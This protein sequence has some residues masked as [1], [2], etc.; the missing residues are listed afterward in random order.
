[1]KKYT[2]R[3][4]A[5]MLAICLVIGNTSVVSA[6][7]NQD[8]TEVVEM[9]EMIADVPEAEVVEVAEAEIA[10]V[11]EAE[12]MEMT[13]SVEVAETESAE[14]TET[15]EAA[16]TE[17]V[18]VTD[19]ADAVE[20]ETAEVT[21]TEVVDPEMIEVIDAVYASAE[22]T[23]FT[24]E[25]F[26][27]PILWARIC[28]EAGKEGAESLTAEDLA[29]ITYIGHSGDFYRGW[30]EEL[31]GIGYLTNLESVYF[32]EEKITDVSPLAECKKLKTIDIREC[33]VT[34]LP[35]F[36]HLENLKTLY[37]I[38]T[39][40]PTSEISEDKYPEGVSTN[41]NAQ[42]P[43]F[44]ASVEG[45]LVCRETEDSDTYY[46]EIFLS[47]LRTYYGMDLMVEDI[48]TG[49]PVVLYQEDYANLS[50]ESVTYSDYNGKGYDAILELSDL[51]LTEGEHTWRVTWTYDNRPRTSTF[52]ITV[53]ADAMGKTW[54]IPRDILPEALRDFML[55]DYFTK[56]WDLNEDGE[57]SYAEVEKMDSLY[58]NDENVQ[59]TNFEIFKYMK[60]LGTLYIGYQKAFDDTWLET[61]CNYENIKK[62]P[63]L[64][65]SNMDKVT[66]LVPLQKLSDLRNLT[67]W[68]MT[69]ITDISSLAEVSTLEHLNMNA[70]RNIAGLSALK[71]LPLTYMFADSGTFPDKEIFDFICSVEEVTVQAGKKVS[72]VS[73]L[74]EMKDSSGVVATVEDESI[75]GTAAGAPF[76]IYGFRAGETVAHISYEGSTYPVKVIVTAAEFDYDPAVGEA[77][78]EE[79][80]MSFAGTEGITS[81]RVS[82]T[83]VDSDDNIW[84]ITTR[85]PEKI[86][87]KDDYTKYA[88]R[89]LY[90]RAKVFGVK[91][92]VS[93]VDFSMY[94]DEA[95][96]LWAYTQNHHGEYSNFA[97]K[98]EV[99]KN[100]ADWQDGGYS[101]ESSYSPYNDYLLLLKTDGSL[102]VYGF[103]SAYNAETYSNSLKPQLLGKLA[104][105][106]VTAIYPH[107][108]LT[109]NG[110]FYRVNY[111]N[112]SIQ[113]KL[114]AENVVKV[115]D[116]TSVTLAMDANGNYYTTKGKQ[117]FTGTVKDFLQGSYYDPNW[118]VYDQ[119]GYIIRTNSD[120]MH[121]GYLLMEDGTLYRTYNS[122]A[123]NY[124]T[125]QQLDVG[126]DK[127]EK[128]YYWKDGNAYAYSGVLYDEYL[129]NGAGRGVYP[130]DAGDGTQTLYVNGVPYLSK[131]V[132]WVVGDSCI[133]AIRVDNTLWMF[134]ENYIPTQINMSEL[135]QDPIAQD[136]YYTEIDIADLRAGISTLSIDWTPVEGAVSYNAYIKNF[137][138]SYT[139]ETVETTGYT[140]SN[141][142]QK[143][144]YNFYIEAV[145]A[146][147]TVIGSSWTFS[148]YTSSPSLTVEK[149]EVERGKTTS[150]ATITVKVAPEDYVIDGQLYLYLDCFNETEEDGYVDSVYEVKEY[151]ECTGGGTYQL[152]ITGAPND[153]YLS[154]NV[155]LYVNDSSVVRQS[156]SFDTKEHLYLTKEDF[157][158]EALWAIIQDRSY[159]LDAYGITYMYIE[160]PNVKDLTGLDKLV[161]LRSLNLCGLDKDVIDI[162]KIPVSVQELRIES[163]GLV[164]IPDLSAF[165][166]LSYLNLYMNR[167]PESE[168]VA[169][170]PALSIFKENYE[171]NFNSWLNGQAMSQLSDPVTYVSD[172]YYRTV[173]NA[174]PFFLEIAKVDTNHS[175][176][177]R[178]EENGINLGTTTTVSRT[179]DRIHMELADLGIAEAC[180]KELSIEVTDTTS[181]EI[182]YNETKVIQFRDGIN[183]EADK[184][185]LTLEGSGLYFRFYLTEEQ[186]DFLVSTGWDENEG[187][188]YGFATTG[189]LSDINGKEAEAYYTIWNEQDVPEEYRIFYRINEVHY[190]YAYRVEVEATVLD[191]QE[192]FVAGPCI[193]TMNGYDGTSA[194]TIDNVAEFTDKSIVHGVSAATALFD[195]QGEYIYA[196][197]NVSQMSSNIPELIVTDKNGNNISS[198]PYELIYAGSWIYKI[199]PDEQYKNRE[200]YYYQIVS[201]YY[202]GELEGY[203]Y[204]ERETPYA[205]GLFVDTVNEEIV[206]YVS[207]GI[208]DGTKVKVNIY[209]RSS[210]KLLKST[211]ATVKNREIHVDFK[212]D[213]SLNPNKYQ[214]EI[215]QGDVQ[216]RSR[217]VLPGGTLGSKGA[218]IATK[219]SGN[220]IYLDGA[221][222][223]LGATI[224]V[225]DPKDATLLATFENPQ[226]GKFESL[227]L[228]GAGL[229]A[230]KV[231]LVNVLFDGGC[232]A[233]KGLFDI[234]TETKD[235][236]WKLYDLNNEEVAP[237]GENAYRLDYTAALKNKAIILE[238]QTVGNADA[239]IKVTSSNTSV[240]SAALVKG[241]KNIKLTVKGVGTAYITVQAQDSKYSEK[242]K[243][244]L[245]DYLPRMDS[246]TLALNR[247]MT[248]NA[249]AAVYPVYNT[250]A[251]AVAINT[252]ALTAKEVTANYIDYFAVSLTET[253]IKVTLLD[254]SERTNAKGKLEAV[255]N[256]TYRIPII[257]TTEEPAETSATGEVIIREN[258]MVLSVKLS[259]TKPTITVKQTEKMNLFY[260]DTKAVYK[261]TTNTGVIE[262][263]ELIVAEGAAVYFE[264]AYDAEA[265]TITM[266]PTDA[267]RALTSKEQSKALKQV[268]SITIG[269]SIL[270]KSITI[271][272]DKTKP[273]VTLDKASHTVYQYAQDGQKIFVGTKL[274]FVALDKKT[275]NVLQDANVKLTGYAVTKKGITTYN[276]EPADPDAVL[277][278][279]DSYTLEANDAGQYSISFIGTASASA[280][281]LVQGA[282]WAE[283]IK[284]TL[285]VTVAKKTITAKLSTTKVT[286]NKAYG[287][288][289]KAIMLTGLLPYD[290][291][292]LDEENIVVTIPKKAVYAEGDIQIIKTENGFIAKLQEG[293]SLTAGSYKVKVPI[294]FVFEEG[295]E[296]TPSPLTLTVTVID[297]NLTSKDIKWKTTGKLDA[298]DR[299]GSGV[300]ATPTVSKL[301]AVLSDVTFSEADVEAGLADK[302]QMAVVDGKLKISLID[303]VDVSTK[304]KFVVHPMIT[305]ATEDGV[306]YEDI[307]TPAI[308]VKP[309]QSSVKV[310]LS[311][312]QAT[313]YLYSARTHEAVFEYKLTGPAGA[314]IDEVTMTGAIA[315]DFAVSYDADSDLI[316]VTLLDDT[317]SAKTYSLKLQISFVDQTTNAKPLSVS[318]KVV[319]KK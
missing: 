149:V 215:L 172:V 191:R 52:N 125:Y 262:N 107:A 237:V 164:E 230:G 93:L 276:F 97:D 65:L 221:N 186:Y 39:A 98:V 231:Y 236:A 288:D 182:V 199:L 19:T 259:N 249:E 91:T 254:D 35:D 222:A 124:A 60:K 181:G 38:Y 314:K 78:P 134:S 306:L 132:D 189:K 50:Y 277:N 209:E 248:L 100:I 174:Y 252:A 283:P 290:N 162:T 282:N 313:M 75:A 251:T 2:R 169:T 312:K 14:V 64:T 273:G 111:S 137:Y 192:D 72:I 226:G 83:L 133:Y 233:S 167:I 310:T 243:I 263:V 21:D 232:A 220:K 253:G 73:D 135:S 281:I 18:E 223:P 255:K 63:Y 318:T 219:F 138:G 229:E 240:V 105:S 297:N 201:D 193:L 183:S 185:Y 293:A 119:H 307:P 146:N 87:E 214:I 45:G 187:L 99:A 106:G 210:D 17:S 244:E 166:K 228:A 10:E 89:I 286:L 143:T 161:K 211:T 116:N 69:G 156:L 272:V 204:I 292:V 302:L 165:T 80:R 25:H 217:T 175:Y 224:K 309:V 46:A 4:L 170:N 26:P 278:D 196:K 268:L 114:I 213:S 178:V 179:G 155:T 82:R 76:D 12:T 301:N 86:L 15:V 319:V 284:S 131:V 109:E 20:T 43:K 168:F 140:F 270:T 59:L 88:A 23:T 264:D 153:F 120:D 247:A 296:Y 41:F 103:T 246:T 303:G 163:C 274:T 234:V 136:M 70:M 127:I 265:G 194:L 227:D 205:N 113:S 202:V 40:L 291:Y 22:I 53:D 300:V 158:D 141:L 102:W 150:N 16:E 94:L 139:K 308:T 176:R 51:E 180:E 250:D 305:L 44:E 101:Q 55:E 85:T 122:E 68:E 130:K 200:D 67:L 13:E 96:S 147:G 34:T 58:L 54:I 299:A 6:A 123:V 279:D 298:V 271:G 71:D 207:S 77:V 152:E 173:D 115:W 112:S 108:Y 7:Q 184:N 129:G 171:G 295:K 24:Q 317:I 160:D 216:L 62:L 11:V 28:S 159:N 239:T 315:E 148:T 285:K 218:S 5:A 145:D 57:Y 56:R 316:R 241:T 266:V 81:A 238:T 79:E 84:D 29:K 245:R 32:S 118:A 190:I 235:I 203:L 258:Q 126:V 104:S 27:D 212:L 208:A 275:K 121:A 142:V 154:G 157:P 206:A 92:T 30:I 33:D 128:D 36:S 3:I 311:P 280:T 37:F 256:G 198:A 49:E 269:E 304:D 48:T 289:Q 257:L 260:T 151:F 287:S 1:M 177:L 66:S 267:F 90:D 225:F 188:G 197:I 8:V 42:V 261:L 144:G 9:S 31:T 74:I 95:G 110:E 195:H 117:N 242:I 294:K 61:I 47:N